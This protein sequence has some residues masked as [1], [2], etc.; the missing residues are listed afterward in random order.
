MQYVIAFEEDS[1]ARDLTVRYAREYG[2]KVS[3]T[4]AGGRGQWQW[5]EGVMGLLTRPYRLVRHFVKL[6]WT[7]NNFFFCR[8]ETT[9]R[10]KS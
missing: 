7:A 4:Q 2:A 8:I 1:Y 5:W 3:K 6:L 9:L 10:M